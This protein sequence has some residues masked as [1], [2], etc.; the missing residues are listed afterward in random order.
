MLV[1]ALGV[2]IISNS[3]EKSS[4]LFSYL[5]H[6]LSPEIVFLLWAAFWMN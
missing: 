6:Y 5:Q 1:A 3:P 2:I 4:V